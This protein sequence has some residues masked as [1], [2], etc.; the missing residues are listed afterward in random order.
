M[1]SPGL[2]F[3]KRARNFAEAL[4]VPLA[5]VEKR[6]VNHVDGS[7]SGLA[8]LGDVAG[9]D[10]I[11]VDDEIATA[12][13][14]TRVAELLVDAG[15][16]SVRAAAIHP[17][18]SEGSVE[19]LRNSENVEQARIFRMEEVGFEYRPYFRVEVAGSASSSPG[20]AAPVDADADPSAK[21]HAGGP[22]DELHGDEVGAA[23]R[24]IFSR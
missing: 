4:G 21:V 6:R 12:H 16:S 2:G 19:R 13:T 15:A 24:G 1:V 10:C 8:I 11:I 7:V 3:A 18:F 5:I 17:L 20:P 9:R 22:S 14:M 23:R